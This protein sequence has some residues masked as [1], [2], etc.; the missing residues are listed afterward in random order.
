MAEP[1]SD[2]PLS[3]RRVP[4]LEGWAVVGL[5]ALLTAAVAAA[6]FAAHGAEGEG[7]RLQIRHSARVS[8]AFFL[9]AFLATPL[10]RLRPN[11]A[12]AWL[13]RNRRGVGVSVGVA[14]AWHGAAIVVFVR[15]T[16]HETDPGTLVAALLAYAFLAAMV[17]TSFDATAAWLGRRRWQL[18]HRTALYYLWFVFGFTFA[19]TAAAGD[20]VSAGYAAAYA[21]ALP[22]RLWG[23]RGRGRTALRGGQ[24]SSRSNDTELMQ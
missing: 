13:L 21:L 9:A 4:G 1:R 3:P 5:A 23:L 19:G 17:A 8:G 24:S 18:L 16:G 15:M 14:H 12:T 7:W 22:L 6:V 11:D 2:A 20:A 10:R